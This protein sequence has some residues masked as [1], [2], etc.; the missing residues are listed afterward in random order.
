MADGAHLPIG[1]NEDVVEVG[2]PKPLHKAEPH[3]PYQE[4]HIRKEV[5]SRDGN[6]NHGIFMAVAPALR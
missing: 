5:R 4:G 3:L 2:L 1:A 6:A